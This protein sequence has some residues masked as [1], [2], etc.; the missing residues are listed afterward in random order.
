M[1]HHIR[2][3]HLLLFS[4]ACFTLS[5]IISVHDRLTNIEARLIALEIRHKK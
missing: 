3:K 1:L 5:S 4:G 2:Q